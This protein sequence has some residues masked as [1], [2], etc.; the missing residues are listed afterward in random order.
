MRV[1]EADD[2]EPAGARKAPGGDVISWVEQEAIW[3]GGQVSPA[4][5]VDDL[6]LGAEQNAA[7]LR[8]C[9][10][11]RVL[12]HECEHAAGKR[13]A[14]IASTAIAIPIPPPMHSAATPYR[15]FRARN[16]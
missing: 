5:S 7:A 8:R 2:L 12:D 11:R 3:V 10:L 13:P 6:W 15:S 1:I 16:A 9:C 14:H 4:D